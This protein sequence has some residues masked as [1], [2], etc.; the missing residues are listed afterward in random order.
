[1]RRAL[2]IVL[3]VAAVIG[4]FGQTVAVVASPTMAAI[5]APASPAM[6]MDCLGMTQGRGNQSVPCDRMTIACVAG[7]GCSIPFTVNG[8]QPILVEAMTVSASPAWPVTSALKGRS[9]QPEP[10]P[11]NS[12]A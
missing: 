7:M 2:K 5:E 4:L 12:M 3:V 10:H 1:M 6:P 9:V 8:A 11:P